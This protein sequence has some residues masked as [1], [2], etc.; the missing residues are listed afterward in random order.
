VLTEAEAATYTIQNVL[1]GTDQWDAD[2]AGRILP[3]PQLMLSGSQL[4]WSDTSGR[5]AC[6]LVITNGQAAVTTAETAAYTAG[7]TVSIQCVNENGVLGRIATV[8]AQGNIHSAVST[9]NRA[10]TSSAV[11]SLTGLRLSHPRPGVNI[12]SGK[13]FLAK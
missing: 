3:E 12:A 11:Y 10:S 9:V 5:A 8:D 2:A 13:K 4:S 7:S 1:S 6:Y